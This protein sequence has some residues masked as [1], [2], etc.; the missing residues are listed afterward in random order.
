MKS[1]K[2]IVPKMN[3]NIF[4]RFLV[5]WRTKSVYIR[6]KRRTFGVLPNENKPRKWCWN[7]CV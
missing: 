1:M 6:Q 3:F 5:S 2:K 4:L 7:N